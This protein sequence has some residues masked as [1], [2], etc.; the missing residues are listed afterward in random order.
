MPPLMGEGARGRGWGTL[1]A[2]FGLLLLA[3][4]GGGGA[5]TD[6]PR[7]LVFGF[8]GG[9]P[10]ALYVDGVGGDDAGDGSTDHPYATLH[11]A[12]A[13]ALPDTDI[14]VRDRYPGTGY[15]E[16]AAP[17]DIPAGVSLH[18]G[19]D[20]AWQ[21]Q[22]GVRTPVRAGAVGLHFADVAADAV[23][24]GFAVRAAPE[25]LPP[26]GALVA[27]VAVDGGRATLT[28]R[29][30][31]LEVA[32]G[33]AGAR[34]LAGVAA[35]HV[36]RVVL[37]GNEIVV[38]DGPGSATAAA[39]GL[40]YWAAA[41]AGADAADGG[42]A[43]G[44]EAPGQA[45]GGDGG[46]GGTTV[47]TRGADGHAGGDASWRGLLA[48]GG[49]G[50][51]GGISSV[52]AGAGGRGQ[53]GAAGMPGLG[54]AGFGAFGAE[55]LPVGRGGEPGD[56]GAPGAGGGGGGGGANLPALSS[57]GG[58]GG[59][60]GAG[61]LGGRPGDG[62]AGGAAVVGVALFDVPDATLMGNTIRTG[63]GGAGGDGGDGG[64]GQ[65]GGPG[66]AG[67]DAG[68]PGGTGGDGGDGGAGGGGGG[69]PSYGIAVGPGLGPV[70][71][72][73]SITAG[74]GGPGGAPGRGAP[75]ATPHHAGGGGASYAVYDADPADG[76]APVLD[77]TNLLDFGRPGAGG[78]GPR[79]GTAGETNF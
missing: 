74:D 32:G 76:A 53:R 35:R 37:A 71:S 77:G 69:G 70:L 18:G 28:L 79:G 31:R 47:H 54:G 23:V 65:S 11:R 36:A 17:L 52:A 40:P 3:A 50:G 43:P 68:A 27:A 48:R 10:A 62:G 25:P 42:G 67:F 20:A 24:E 49:A 34:A 19:L 38:G 44:G 33:A 57:G 60:G 75:P 64:P 61:G 22:P 7:A 59:G 2:G 46:D 12:L 4:C 66:G 63:T 8:G 58:G 51:P 13:A 16:T 56:A 78:D 45:P 6:G 21:P 39:G 15:D 55:G 9:A 14:R 29:D 72:G 5:A 26:P 73:N 1:T 41:P 30:N